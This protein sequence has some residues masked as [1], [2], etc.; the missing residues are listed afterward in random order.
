M[1]FPNPGEA[2]IVDEHLSVPKVRPNEMPRVIGVGVIG[3][4]WMG[5]VHSRSYRQIAELFPEC[6]L[7]PKLVICADS[8]EDRASAARARFGFEKQTTNWKA[9]I[10]DPAVEVVNIATPNNLHL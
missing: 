2:T 3:M 6:P 7:H 4:G 9:V 5:E 8:V 1:G 10:E